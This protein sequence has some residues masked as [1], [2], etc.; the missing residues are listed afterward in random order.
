MRPQCGGF[1]RQ[2]HSSQEGECQLTSS[3]S[4]DFCGGVLSGELDRPKPPFREQVYVVAFAASLILACTLVAV[5]T[6]GLG[7]MILLHGDYYRYL[8]IT[9]QILNGHFAPST[10]HFWGL[11][12]L[13][14]ALITVTHLSPVTLYYLIPVASSLG[15]TWLVTRLWGTW[16]GVTFT[17]CNW[18]WI[19]AS[20]Y[21]GADSLFVFL[22]FFAI[23]RMQSRRYVWAVLLAS[24]ATTVRPLGLF[25]VCVIVIAAWRELGSRSAVLCLTVSAVI[26]A[27]YVVPLL[28]SLH[29]P[30]FNVHLYQQ[31][32][33][34]GGLPVSLPLKAIVTN[35]LNGRNVGNTFIKNAKAV[36]VLLHVAALLGL[37]MSSQLRRRLTEQPVIGAFVLLYSAFILTYNAPWWALSIYP[38]LM[39]P[40]LPFLLWLYEKWL[41]RNWV[42]WTAVACVT[43]VLACGAGLGFGRAWLLLQG[44]TP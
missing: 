1:P 36:F 15:A 37:A 34:G 7:N 8:D 33:W 22:V 9:N 20:S 10:K 6:V 32:D 27:L 12:Y 16:V 31:Q 43:M 23:A 38:R 30:L 14:A 2:S 17:A 3:K 40:V 44:R 19:E 5:W 29:D 41:P 35:Y 18:M 11:P 42:V 26:G 13:M 4:V 24:L 28:R 39:I 25:L 21:G